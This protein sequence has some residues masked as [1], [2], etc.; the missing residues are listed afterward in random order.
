M[1]Y[2]D[3]VVLNMLQGMDAVPSMLHV[4]KAYTDLD[5]LGSL[6]QLSVYQCILLT[7]KGRIT[8]LVTSL[9]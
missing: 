2:L 4:Q 3:V 9:F 6:R 5:F 8:T 7:L 1:Q